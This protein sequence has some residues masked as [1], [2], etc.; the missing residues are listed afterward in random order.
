MADKPSFLRRFFGGIW[1]LFTFVYRSIV[2]LVFVALAAVIWMGVQGQQAPVTVQDN[3]ALVWHPVG[4]IVEQTDRDPTEEYL[5]NLAGEQP[6]QTELRDLVE[7][8]DKAAADS[9]IRLAVLWLDSLYYAGPAQLKEMKAAIARF[10]DSGKRVVAYAPGYTQRSYYLAAQADEVIMD[11]MGLVLLEGYSVYN[12]YFPGLLDKLGV[13]M[14]I[15]QAGDYKSAVEPYARQDMSPEAREATQQ[16]LDTL[17]DG[18]T[19]DVAAGRAM[20]RDA[21][22]GYVNNFVDRLQGQGGDTA[23]VAVEAKLVDELLPLECF[24]EKIAAVVGMDDDDYSFRQI[25]FRRYLRSMRSPFGQ[26]A[27]GSGPKVGVVTVQ[28]TIVQGESGEGYAGADTVADLLDDAAQN[29]DIAAVVLRVNS[30]GGGIYASE[31][32]RRAV[33]R[34]KAAGKPVVVSMSTLA[35]SGGYWISA[36][37]DEIFAHDTTITGSIGVFGLFPTFEGTLDKIGVTTDGLGTTPFAGAFRSD[38]PLSEPVETSINLIIQHDYR[39]FLDH[40]AQGRELSVEQVDDIAQGRVWSGLDALEVGLVDQL[41]GFQ[42]AVAAAASRAGIDPANAKLH[43]LRPPRDISFGFL[44]RFILALESAGQFK[45]ASLLGQWLPD[46]GSTGPVSP[47]VTAIER[48]D[49]R[50]A[51]AHCLCEVAP[52]AGL[53]RSGVATGPSL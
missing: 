38:R 1:T 2:I 52:D 7:S 15:F 47:W 22:L 19:D 27:T 16:W 32:M 43:Y 31:V 18:Y 40:V 46:S 51:Y 26:V 49:P 28:G 42:D 5:D 20:D 9:R 30:P 21:I 41:G 48:N 35:A 44:G 39:L 13:K 8:L 6:T 33:Q 34:V 29:D 37:A 4:N 14:H 11:P 17:W 3:V 12:N 50:S 24:R 25:N 45:L 10:K 53:A 36:P 23:K